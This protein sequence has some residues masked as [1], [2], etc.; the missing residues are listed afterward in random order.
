LRLVRA[1][2]RAG[3]LLAAGGIGL[4]RPVRCPD[5]ARRDCRCSRGG[6]AMSG[7]RGTKATSVNADGAQEIQSLEIRRSRRVRSGRRNPPA[8]GTAGAGVACSTGVPP[9]GCSM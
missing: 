8:S 7:N 1:R 4:A 5:G 9:V 3:H 6:A 2:H